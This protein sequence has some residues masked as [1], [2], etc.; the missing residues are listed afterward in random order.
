MHT[1]LTYPR[2]VIAGTHSGVGK[3][4]FTVGLCRA[5]RARGL[6]VAMFKCGPDYLDPTYHARAAG[7]ASHN[8]DSWMM[9][10]EALLSTFEQG[11]QNTDIALIEGVMGLFDGASPS[12]EAGSTAE[13]A[14]WLDA[15]VLLLVDASGMARTL[16]A[17]LLGFRTFDP[18]LLIAG[19]ICN[20][21][22]SRSHLDI[23]KN[24]APEGFI[25]GA[26]PK[27]T[28]LAFPERHLGLR[29]ANDSVL[30]DS[31]LNAWGEHVSQW[32]SLESIVKLANEAP[33]LPSAKEVIAPFSGQNTC[34]IGVAV[35]EAFHFYYQD[36]LRRLRELGA[37]LVTFSPIRDA[38][39]PEVDGLYFGGGYPELF[40]RELAQN[41]E[42]RE[43]VYSFAA[44]GGPIY[45]ECGGLMYLSTLLQTTDGAIH[46]MVGWIPAKTIM[47]ER[48][49]ALGYVE[50]E[51]QQQTILG[52]AG[53]K[54]RGHQFRYSDLQMLGEISHAYSLRKRRNGETSSEGYCRGNVVASYVHAHWASNPSL[55]ESFVQACQSS[56]VMQGT[57]QAAARS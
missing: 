15:P 43:D 36:N 35:D 16:G 51:T 12:S 23:L 40:A 5:L 32:C 56:A 14:K 39:L 4:T 22:G 19:A 55:A 48:L 29:T 49:Q 21:V 50:V 28:A 47:Q 7:L 45:G 26:L 25:L 11:C 46:P 33:S 44:K 6:R 2:L 9:G 24:A 17:L 42:M 8:L 18:E 30:P 57:R 20:R 41:K 52:P 34:R 31:L 27:Q 10:R 53:A 54:F 1:K 38:H 37:T 3:T 13:I